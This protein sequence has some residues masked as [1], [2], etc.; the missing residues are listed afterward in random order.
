[1]K[2]LRFGGLD[3]DADMIREPAGGNMHLL[4]WRV[5][6]SRFQPRQNDLL[7]LIAGGEGHW[8]GIVLR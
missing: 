2:I 1:M 8:V 4:V 6:A 7:D 3:V 5:P